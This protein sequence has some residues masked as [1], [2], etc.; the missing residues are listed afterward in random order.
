MGLKDG[1]WHIAYR[2]TPQGTILS[3][4]KTTF[5]VLP[6]TLTLCAMDSLVV[7]HEG[8]TYIFAEVYSIVHHRGFIGYSRFDGKQFT[9]WKPIIK[10]KYHLSYPYVFE[11]DG[12]IYMIPESNEARE[13]YAYKAVSFPD[14]WEKAYVLKSGVRYVDTSRFEA[15]GKEYAYTYDIDADPHQLLLYELQDGRMIGDGKLL[16]T[17]DAVARPGGYPFWEDGALIRPSQD[18]DGAYGKAV[19]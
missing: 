1:W 7:E 10:E 4:Q 3:D 13:V 19:A 6:N 17:D 18:C 15:N 9:K 2:E 5:H 16:S 8:E 11:K 14:T 12:E